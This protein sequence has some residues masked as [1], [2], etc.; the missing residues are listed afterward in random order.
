MMDHLKQ[1]SLNRTKVR[2]VNRPD[3]MHIF[4]AF[5]FIEGNIDELTKQWQ[6]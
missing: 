2:Q 1:Q 6:P 5:H 3:I 4:T